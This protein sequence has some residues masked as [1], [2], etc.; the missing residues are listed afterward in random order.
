MKPERNSSP[1]TPAKYF[2]LSEANAM[3][4]LVRAITH[5]LSEQAQ[6]LHD[7]RE[8]LAYFQK[9]RK[10]FGL[11]QYNDEVDQVASALSKEDYRLDA[12]VA[13][14][15]ALGVSVQDALAGRVE[16]PSMRDGEEIR[17]C[18][19]LGEPAVAHWREANEADALWP[20]VDDSPKTLRAFDADEAEAN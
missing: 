5:D 20:L 1:T 4:P 9:R 2:T 3:L 7:R 16:F 15:S 17:L 6:E 18:W 14:L 10:S 12:Y 19:Q 13:E 8:R 11:S